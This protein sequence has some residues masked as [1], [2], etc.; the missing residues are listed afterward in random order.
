MNQ[1]QAAL[2]RELLL[3]LNTVNAFLTQLQGLAILIRKFKETQ[4]NV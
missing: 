4:K 2:K 3:H 1:F